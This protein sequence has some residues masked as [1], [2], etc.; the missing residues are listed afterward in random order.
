L[1]VNS[2]NERP[3][4]A[5]V[6]RVIRTLKN[7]AKMLFCNGFSLIIAIFTPFLYL[8]LV[9]VHEIAGRF[10]PELGEA[11]DISSFSVWQRVGITLL[12]SLTCMLYFYIKFVLPWHESREAR[13]TAKRGGGD[14]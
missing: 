8:F 10:W 1:R 11:L 4:S 7:H 9:R 5:M 13:E 3:I 12:T 14:G 2:M 6:R